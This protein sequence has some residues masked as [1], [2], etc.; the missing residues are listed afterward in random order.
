V[1]VTGHADNTCVCFTVILPSTLSTESLVGSRQRICQLK[2]V[3]GFSQSIRPESPAHLP[4]P[5]PHSAELSQAGSRAPEMPACLYCGS[6]PGSSPLLDHLDRAVAHDAVCFLAAG[7]LHEMHIAQHACITCRCALSLCCITQRQLHLGNS[8]R[9]APGTCA[10]RVMHP[11][12]QTGALDSARSACLSCHHHQSAS[13]ARS[14][15]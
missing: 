1:L 5:G 4:L 11:P 15:T 14:R 3:V 12:H 9:R 2:D 10:S 7:S 6:L 13:R 8:R